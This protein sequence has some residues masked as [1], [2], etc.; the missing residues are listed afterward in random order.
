MVTAEVA[1]A[2]E[3][4]LSVV[5]VL[6]PEMQSQHWGPARLSYKL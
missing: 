5:P 6:V 2:C 3:T 4:N 1:A